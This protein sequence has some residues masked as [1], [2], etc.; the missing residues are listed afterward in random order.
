MTKYSK[1]TIY[2]K[3]L[4]VGYKVKKGFVH[5]VYNGAV[6]IN[7]DGERETGYSVLNLRTNFSVSGCYN[8]CYD[9]LWSLEE[10]EEFIKAIYDSNNLEY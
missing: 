7:S 8:D 1:K 5:Y 4:E 2:K 3:A 9:N 6:F 10:V